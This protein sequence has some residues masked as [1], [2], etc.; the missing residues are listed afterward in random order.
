[1]RAHQTYLPEPLFLLMMEQRFVI[2]SRITSPSE[3]PMVSWCWL[4]YDVF[5]VKFVLCATRQQ[6]SFV[7]WLRE[8]RMY[9]IAALL[10]SI[11]LQFDVIH[12]FA[13]PTNLWIGDEVESQRIQFLLNNE[14]CRY[15]QR[16]PKVVVS[17]SLLKNNLTQTIVKYEREAKTDISLRRKQIERNTKRNGSWTK[18][19]PDI[20]VPEKKAR[21]LLWF[22]FTQATTYTVPLCLSSR[23]GFD[24]FYWTRILFMS[25]QQSEARYIQDWREPRPITL[26]F[27]P[28]VSRTK[29]DKTFKPPATLE[30]LFS[31]IS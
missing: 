15:Y 8:T 7:F 4:F 10:S 14:M 2:C 3:T 31:V 17:S 30:S 16:K 26:F 9:T 18:Q 1:M 28:E 5:V 19:F 27:K 12:G 25:Q 29:R 13:I 20:A 11:Y 23:R 24:E 6:F 22:T 21:S